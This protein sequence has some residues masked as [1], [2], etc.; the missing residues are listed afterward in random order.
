M[1]PAPPKAAQLKNAI[2]RINAVIFETGEGIA[3][4]MNITA[5][6]G[7]KMPA[8]TAIVLPVALSSW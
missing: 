1:S 7:M 6:T 5:K 4:R 2:V 8:P 3:A